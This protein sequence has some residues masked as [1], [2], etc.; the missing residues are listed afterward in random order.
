MAII[1]VGTISGCALG[2]LNMGLKKYVAKHPESRLS[3]DLQDGCN[4]QLHDYIVPVLSMALGCSFVIIALCGVD[5][6]HCFKESKEAMQRWSEWWFESVPSRGSWAWASAIGLGA[7]HYTQDLLS[8]N[9]AGLPLFVHHV[10]AVVHAFCLQA[11][12]SWAG[13][14]LTWS[15]VYEA[16]SLLLCLG[17]VG[18]VPR[19]FGHWAAMVTTCFGMALGVHGMIVRPVLSELNGA[20][21]FCVVALLLLGLGRIQ[22]AVESLR[23]LK[24]TSKSS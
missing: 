20:A 11:S 23:S 15:G 18:T 3:R 14:L 12:S 21:W 10:F 17:Y 1:V 16:G 4:R 6:L 24:G 7:G 2:A 5:C 9:W 13:M 22:D 19:C 8:N